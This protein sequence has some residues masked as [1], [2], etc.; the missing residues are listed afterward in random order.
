[1]KLQTLLFCSAFLFLT[2]CGSSDS[3]P[4]D[5]D[6]DG[7]PDQ[8]DNCLNIANPD[9]SDLDDNGQ[10]DLCDDDMDG[11][12]VNNAEDA[13]PKDVTESVDVDGDGI[14]DNKDLDLQS[15]NINSIKMSRLLDNQRAVK[16]TGGYHG[17]LQGDYIYPNFG[18][19]VENV[20]DVNGDG[21]D[22]FVIGTEHAD[23]YSPS[24]K[25]RFYRL[26]GIA[27][28]IFGSAET[29]P[30]SVDLDSL[31]GISHVKLRFSDSGRSSGFG[32]E[33]EALGDINKDGLDDFFIS[34]E[35]DFIEEH[36]GSAFI[37]FGRN[38]WIQEADEQGV[39]SKQKLQE[40]A[41]SYQGFQGS[42]QFGRVVR[43]IGDVNHDGIVDVALVGV[44]DRVFSMSNAGELYI[45]FGS[46]EWKPENAGSVY[47]IAD[48]NN[49][50]GLV[51]SKIHHAEEDEVKK[52]LGVEVVHTGDFN[53][54]GID[55]FA[56]TYR[57]GPEANE[58]AGVYVVFGKESNEWAD[59][60][61]VDTFAQTDFMRIDALEPDSTKPYWGGW[62]HM[63]RELASGDLNGDG[64]P[65]LVVPT[66]G[67]IS[68]EG[69]DPAHPGIVSIYWGDRG[70]WPTPFDR[71]KMTD[72]LGV[73]LKGAE[74]NLEFGAGVEVVSDWNGDGI[75]ELIVSANRMGET[76]EE[77][78]ND[79]YIIYGKE[80]WSE[81]S[82]G[83]ETANEN[84]LRIQ[85]DGTDSRG[86]PYLNNIGDINNDGLDDFTVADPAMS[87]NGLTYNGELYIIYGFKEL[88]P[89]Q[90]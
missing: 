32:S 57:S 37:V 72:F 56:F 28:L 77:R 67:D 41:V 80:N 66:I 19:N 15:S 12:G 83:A 50:N 35:S 63:G 52:Y 78:Q 70:D 60:Y 65:D 38:S 5:S 47:N 46:D 3:K 42:H 2:A 25:S 17:D 11:D 40:N 43:N 85:M 31:E 61:T 22:D 90:K 58:D 82:I 59:V 18:Q 69:E 36:V 24:E 64:K 53:D 16:V 10:G 44:Q 74:N 71:T 29:L 20:G 23:F 26:G 75:S 84:V 9:Q 55:D 73:N 79:V 76:Q 68:A 87:S 1:M 62:K 33:V 49:D 30:T 86:V 7:I 8:T 27:Y 21:Y 88:Y 34:I 51:I 48:L 4:I 54:D 14:G 45:L 39:I 89:S 6:A 13:F 81:M